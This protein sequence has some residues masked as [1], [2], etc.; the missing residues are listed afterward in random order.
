MKKVIRLR[1]IVCFVLSFILCHPS[2]KA[3]RIFSGLPFI[4]NYKPGDY[5]G[6]ILNWQIIQD[7]RGLIYIANNFGVLEFDGSQWRLY[8]VPKG[9]KVRSIS[10]DQTGKIFV[11]SQGDFG[12]FSAD[13]RG[14]YTFQSLVDKLPEQ[15]RN[16][17]EVWKVFVGEGKV[18]FCTFSNIYIYDGA[19]SNVIQTN[20]HLEPSFF[21]HKKLYIQSPGHPLSILNKFNQIQPIRG[22]EVYTD[23][24]VTGI[25]P[26]S[27]NQLLIAT[28]KSGLYL[29]DGFDSKKWHVN[30]LPGTSDNM[31][32]C[33]LRL[34]NGNI[35]LG[36][37]SD[38]LFI[39]NMYGHELLHINKKNGLASNTVLCLFQDVAENLWVGMN[40]GISHIELASPITKIDDNLGV[41]GTGYAA[42][43]SKNRL[44]LGT[45]IGLFAADQQDKSGHH[46]GILQYHLVRQSEGQVYNLQMISGSLFMGHHN[47]AYIVYDDHSKR[48]SSTGAWTFIRNPVIPSKIILGTYS[49]ISNLYLQKNNIFD[50]GRMYGFYESSRVMELD[51]DNFLW[52]THGYKGAFRL[53]IDYEKDTI[54][55][56]KFY[57]SQ[58]GFPSD[59][60][61]N[62][63][64][65]NHELL[66]TAERGIYQYDKAK[67]Q[68][69]LHPLYAK[70][71]GDNIH[72][73]D[74]DEDPMGNIYFITNDQCGVIKKNASGELTV[75]YDTFNKIP[76]LLNDDL[77]NVNALDINNVLFSAKEGFIHYQPNKNGTQYRASTVLI[78]K[79]EC[80]TNNDSVLFGGNYLEA[81][82]GNMSVTSNIDTHL[83]YRDNDLRF[84]FASPFYEGLEEIRY[85]YQLDNFD[86]DWSEWT[87][88]TDKEYTNLPEG[89]YTFKVRARNIF[90]VESSVVSYR[91]DIAP[92]WYRSY[93]AY[94]GYVLAG[95]FVIVFGMF[96]VDR[97]H[98]KEKLIIK[99]QQKQE[100]N[101]VEK[102][103]E[104]M[105]EQKEAEITKLKNDKLN[106][107]LDHKNSE[108]A[109]ASMHLL[110]KNALLGDI[111]AKLGNIK[112]QAVKGETKKAIGSILKE[113]EKSSNLDQDWK[114]FEFHFDRVHSEFNKRIREEY[115]QLTPQ[116]MKLCAYLRLNF[117]TKEIAQLL[118]I[119]VRGV[120]I[121][122]YRLRKK[123]GLNR[124]INLAEFILN[125]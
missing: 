81:M 34:Q 32:N 4:N 79:V 108:L 37:Q 69:V 62:V 57:N 47:G 13:E 114:Q 107:E 70:L 67:D 92:P 17:D 49:G 66:F 112:E 95:M 101:S 121:S 10:V 21:V 41:E 77:V 29:Y 68:F 38:G 6:G 80:T 42:A 55:E 50:K 100:L 11:G 122:R 111:R 46:P 25:L 91:F 78:R 56:V 72:I 115:P 83:S 59:I 36:T 23:K 124:D 82:N 5:H 44:F 35:V 116:E 8:P 98:K 19:K 16:I 120:E 87:Y 20:R 2:L 39:L 65:I 30:D 113:I 109:S 28:K 27:K 84:A 73:R 117:A 119:S 43:I 63:F 45:N 53:K 40:N 61:I 89:N 104:T 105:Q 1:I 110:T 86:R 24:L 96:M 71:L 26:Y 106:A 18:Y 14:I 58:D 51:D 118:H 31:I 99:E 3:Q 64:K 97:K 52:M 76:K 94:A 12:Y 60:L 9:T 102:E 48:L 90:G 123:L 33:T 88:K 74:M 125:F 15:F 85:K 103:L 75:D 22:G 93:L 7:R 54:E